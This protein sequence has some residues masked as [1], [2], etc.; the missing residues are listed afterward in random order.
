MLAARVVPSGRY[1]KGAL[2]GPVA[3]LRPGSNNVPYT[4]YTARGLDR[5]TSLSF[6]SLLGFDGVY[7]LRHRL[8]PAPWN[9]LS[10]ILTDTVGSLLYLLQGPLYILEAPLQRLPDGGVH[11]SGEQGVA[12]IPGVVLGEVLLFLGPVP[13]VLLKPLHHLA[14]L[15]AQLLEPRPLLLDELLVQLFVLHKPSRL[16]RSPKVLYPPGGHKK[17]ATTYSP[18]GS[19]PQ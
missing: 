18:T 6:V 8:E 9:G 17:W 16:F 1:E 11:L 12:H 15:H 7:R 13:L 2:A 14:Q 3:C 5:G 4:D 19:P 10:G